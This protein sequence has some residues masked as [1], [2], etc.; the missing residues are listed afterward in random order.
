MDR[1][2]KFVHTGVCEQKSYVLPGKRVTLG[3]YLSKYFSVGS[4]T[5]PIYTIEVTYDQF[6]HFMKSGMP[7]NRDRFYHFIIRDEGIVETRDECMLRY[8]F[9][10]YL[11]Q[12]PFAIYSFRL[13]DSALP[14][15]ISFMNS[16]DWKHSENTMIEMTLDRH[17]T[18]FKNIPLENARGHL[19][20]EEEKLLWFSDKTIRLLPGKVNS[21]VLSDTVK[22]QKFIQNFMNTLDSNYRVGM[23]NDFD[24]A[25][26]VY[27]YLFDSKYAS[28]IDISPLSITYAHSQTER[29]QNGVQVLKPS[30]TQWE[31]RPIGT[32]EHNKG[33]CSGQSRLMRSLLCNPE[34]KIASDAVYGTIPSGESHCWNEFVID[35]KTYQCCTTMKGLFQDL[36]EEGY[37]PENGSYFPYVYPHESLYFFEV[38]KIK[39]H[40]KSLKK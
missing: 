4:K 34:M 37:V 21:T 27:H 2:E 23:M 38:E 39:D 28:N 7:Y 36:D 24:K 6:L 22:L 13:S 12:L 31:S 29:N 9:L 40:V 35:E 26:L 14:A 32:L 5:P 8:Q 20:I 33:V 25:Y 16:V 11:N 1:Y 19:E 3:S 18:S 10:K 15:Y 17:P 30:I